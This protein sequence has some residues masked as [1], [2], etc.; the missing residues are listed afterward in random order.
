MSQQSGREIEIATAGHFKN[1]ARLNGGLCTIEQVNSEYNVRIPVLSASVRDTAR[2]STGLAQASRLR[3][4]SLFARDSQLSRVYWIP[5]FVVVVVALR[6]FSF[7]R[8]LASCS[9]KC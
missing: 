8:I 5:T 6:A 1:P 9:A 2:T 3:H 4:V 7:V